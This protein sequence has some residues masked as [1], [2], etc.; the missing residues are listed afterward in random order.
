M[1]EISI[2]TAVDQVNAVLREAFEGTTTSWSYFTDGPPESALFGTLAKLSAAEASQPIGGT[3]IAAHVQ[4]TAFGLRVSAA[5]VRGDRSPN[6]WKESWAVTTVDD[7]AWARLQQQLRQDYE[8]LFTA[9]AGQGGS[10]VEAFGGAV[11]AVAHV[12][13][14]L[15]AIRQKLKGR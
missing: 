12:A 10:S 2:S 9:I 6:D 4:H 11:G 1:P 14:H 15:G 7:G 13:Y 3:S 5:W 8:A